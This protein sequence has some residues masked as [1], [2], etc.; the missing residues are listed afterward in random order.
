MHPAISTEDLLKLPITL[1]EASARDEIAQKVR[2]SRK[3]HAQ[4]KQLLEIVKT[5]V[6][7]TIEA[8]EKSRSTGLINSLIT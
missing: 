2:S 8:D 6:E 1:P 3:A 4:S 5:G 7:Q